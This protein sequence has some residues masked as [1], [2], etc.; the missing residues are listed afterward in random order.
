VAVFFAAVFLIFAF[1]IPFIS[2]GRGYIPPYDPKRKSRVIR[3]TAINCFTKCSPCQSADCSCRKIP[4]S[5][6][7]EKVLNSMKTNGLGFL[8][9]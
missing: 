8:S 9:A 2:I 1:A 4:P 6:A 5:R 7:D 3:R